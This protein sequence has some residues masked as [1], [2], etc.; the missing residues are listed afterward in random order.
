MP[1]V[2]DHMAE[3]IDDIA[4]LGTVYHHHPAGEPPLSD[5]VWISLG[6]IDEST[7]RCIG[8]SGS[9]MSRVAVTGRP[10]FNKNTCIVRYEAP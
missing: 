3:K 1:F 5:N 9:Q 7:V 10:W 2:C 8:L 6:L 4:Q